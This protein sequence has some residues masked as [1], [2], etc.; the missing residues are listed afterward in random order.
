MSRQLIILPAAEED[1]IEA[2]GWYEEQRPGLGSDWILNVEATLRNV[3]RHPEAFSMIRGE[4]RRA[5]IR[6]FPYGVFYLVEQER[7]IVLAI[8]HASRDPK[9]WPSSR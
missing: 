1:L 3:E 9:R 2:Y 4:V 5:F 6:R 8:L 7:I